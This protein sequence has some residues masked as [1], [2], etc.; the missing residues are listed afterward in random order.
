[1]NPALVVLPTYNERDNIE[2]ILKAIIA[3]DPRLDV[4]VVDDNSPDRTGDIADAFA[5]RE[6]R[7]K[8]LH[9]AGKEGL[10]RAYIAG[11]KRALQEPYEFIFEMDADFSHKP[12]DL[13][14]FLLALEE[15]RADICL[16]SRRV[17]GGGTVNWGVG[18]QLLSAGGSLYSRSVLGIGVR[19]VTGGFKCFRRQVLE[20]LPLDEVKSSGY[21]FQIELTYRAI[22]KGFKVIEIPIIFEDRRV[23]RS[24]MSRAVFVEA[25][26]MVVRLRADALLGRL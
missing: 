20:A 15:Q 9:R 6:P 4:L 8:V 1:M 22:R 17:E 19:D 7:V 10:G 16:G 21:G 23:G 18:R 2:P 11:F 12:S 14:R 24:K 13:P 25:L 3:A 26:G 5:A